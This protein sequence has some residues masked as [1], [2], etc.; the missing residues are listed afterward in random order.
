MIHTRLQRLAALAKIVNLAALLSLLVAELSIAKEKTMVY[1][2]A[3]AVVAI[4]IG[5]LVFIGWL[6]ERINDVIFGKRHER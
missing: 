6:V 2:E 3:A 1:L 5:A 4:C